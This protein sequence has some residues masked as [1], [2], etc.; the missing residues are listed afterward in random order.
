MYVVLTSKGALNHS[1][2]RASCISRQK[3]LPKVTTTR[4]RPL[5]DQEEET[6]FEE[7]EG[8]ESI[9]AEEN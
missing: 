5:V 7:N 1:K 3:S 4:E 9:C 6:I 2:R 8:H